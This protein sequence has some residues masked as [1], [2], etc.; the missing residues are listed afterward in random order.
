[1]M[2]FGVVLKIL[3]VVVSLFLLF[4]CAVLKAE[5]DSE[6]GSHLAPVTVRVFGPNTDAVIDRDRELQVS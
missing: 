5:V 1:M 2:K 3:M 4:V 6:N